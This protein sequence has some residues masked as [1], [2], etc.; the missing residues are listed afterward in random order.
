MA[1]D[2][3][4]KLIFKVTTDV[5]GAKEG[6]KSFDESMKDT[7]NEAKKTEKEV[8][9]ASEGISLKGVA[10]ATAVGTAVVKMSKEISKATATIQSGQKTIVNATGAGEKALEGLMNSAKKVFASSDESFDDVSR[11]I[12]EINTRLGLTGTVLENTTSKFLDFA[13]ATGQDVQ[14]SIIGVTQA[15]NRWGIETEK[16]PTLLD[17][18]T[19]AGQASGVSVA[20]LTTNLTANAGTLQAMG[21]SLDEAISMMMQFEMQGIDTNSVIMG[22]KKSFEDSAKAG[23]DARVDWEKLLDS[24]TNAT[25]E[26]DANRIAVETFGSRIATDMVTA[27]RSGSLE[28][29]KFETAIANAGGTLDST[30]ASA[31]TTADRIVEFKNRVTVALSNIGTA[32]SPFIDTMLPKLAESIETTIGFVTTIVTALTGNKTAV[33][34]LNTAVGDLTTATDTYRTATANLTTDV[35]SMTEAEKRLLKIQQDRAKLAVDQSMK[36]VAEAFAQAKVQIADTASESERLQ[37][38]LDALD[39]A[40]KAQEEDLSLLYEARLELMQ[41]QSDGIALT[42]REQSTFDTLTDLILTRSIQGKKYVENLETAYEQTYAT[43]LDVTADYEQSTLDLETSLNTLATA[44]ADGLLDL[45]KYR[46]LY[47]ELVSE[48]EAYAEAMKT[49]AD[50]TEDNDDAGKEQVKTVNSLN[51]GLKANLTLIK[52][53]LG[54]KDE[55]TDATEENNDAQREAERLANERAKT[56]ADLNKRLE[57]QDR[58][59][60]EQIADEAELAGSIESAYSIRMQLLD[61]EYARELAT[62]MARVKANEATENDITKLKLLYANKQTQLEAEKN[63]K[64]QAYEKAT[65]DKQKELKDKAQKDAEDLAKAIKQK[66]KDTSFA[67]A[68]TLTSLMSQIAGIFSGISANLQAELDIMNEARE[69]D[70]ERY[71]AQSDEKLEILDAEHE[72][73]RISDD[74]YAK[75]RKQIEAELAKSVK[76]RTDKDASAEAELRKKIDEMN[77]KAFNANKESAIAQALINGANAVLRGY[78]ELG[79][80]GGSINAGIQAGITAAQIA[81]ISG[82]EYVPSYAI[83]SSFIP[84]D[85]LAYVHQGEM[86]LRKAD[87]S[88]LKD[89]GGMYGVEQMASA[90][91][92]MDTQRLS[93]LNIN[94]QLSAVIEVDGTQLGIAVLRNIDN[95]SQFVLRG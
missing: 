45:D 78:A 83:G 82:Q 38:K 23:T 61:E 17:K 29:D 88:R 60:R 65:A 13:D 34:E 56:T 85:Q 5:E 92:S 46:I 24:I 68:N 76:E 43:L 67:I 86:I 74:E 51:A 73:G 6:M 64:I 40:F 48:V 54:T 90:P 87:A 9:K 41:K 94:N 11:A 53:L 62:L 36:G 12:G 19:Y 91:L 35:D 28:F 52:E 42:E 33:D 58:L 80:I 63:K 70:L 22:M 18:L 15:M 47:P 57:E 2:V 4:G 59:L 37:G 31:K 72:A 14:Q 49:S 30:D 3:V 16:L 26:M 27:L 79:P 39:I 20:N 81:V 77:R 55:D 10:I 7:Q 75:R 21:Y 93:P 89:I 32:L 69:K 84:T 8:T 95:A 44:F 71:R 66:V 50:A 25:D 1:D